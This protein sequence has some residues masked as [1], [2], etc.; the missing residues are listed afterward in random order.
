MRGRIRYFRGPPQGEVWGTAL[1]RT[2]RLNRPDHTPWH[3]LAPL[4]VAKITPLGDVPIVA[5]PYAAFAVRTT[6]RAGRARRTK[7]SP[8]TPTPPP[9]SSAST[10]P[11]RH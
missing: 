5:K 8:P 11:P 3:P 10:A 2:P 4:V 1:P 9:Q 7:M 6:G